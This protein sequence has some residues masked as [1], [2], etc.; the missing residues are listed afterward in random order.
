MIFI[1]FSY[2]KSNDLKANYNKNKKALK[3]FILTCFTILNQGL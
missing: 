2:I 1:T 3:Y